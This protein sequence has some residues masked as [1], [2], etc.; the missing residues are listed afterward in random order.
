MLQ[1]DS[2]EWFKQRNGRVTASN[3]HKISTPMD[4]L[5]NQSDGNA[6]NLIKSLLYSKPI[7]N[8]ATRHGKAT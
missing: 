6:D 3:L 1:S 4:T 5:R 8:Y 7:D 2:D